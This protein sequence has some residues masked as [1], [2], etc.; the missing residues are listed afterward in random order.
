MEGFEIREEIYEGY[1]SK[2][3]LPANFEKLEAIYRLETLI[4]ITKSLIE[5]KEQVPQEE[6][7]EA[8]RKIQK[9]LNYSQKILE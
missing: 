2:N 5:L 6:K 7:E 9:T 1:R 8:E 4:R 3:K